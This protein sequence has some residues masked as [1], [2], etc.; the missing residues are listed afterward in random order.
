LQE[1]CL[2]CALGHPERLPRKTP[3]RDRPLRHG[4]AFFIRRKDGAV[5][6][7]KRPPKGLLGGMTEIPVTD[8]QIDFDP[9][10]AAGQAPV[11]ATYRRLDRGIAHGFT[12]FTLQLDVYVAEITRRRVP[13]GYRFVPEC[14]LDNEALPSVMRKVIEAVRED[15]AENALKVAA[16]GEAMAGGTKARRRKASF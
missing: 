2:G 10:S 5:L 13:V 16:V 4:A 6:V 8:W 9:A 14:D 1:L 12:H 3:R 15:N 11:A 7:R